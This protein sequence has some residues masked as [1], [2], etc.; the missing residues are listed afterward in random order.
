MFPVLSAAVLAAL[1][2]DPPAAYLSPDGKGLKH[3]LVFREEQGGFA[4]TSV[5][6]WRVEPAGKWTLAKFLV[7]DGKERS[8]TRAAT[9]GTLPAADLAKLATQLAAER[10]LDLPAE[11]GK[12]GKVNPHTYKLTFGPKTVTLAG[13]PPRLGE[14]LKPNLLAA[15]PESDPTAAA[16]RR[17]AGVAE[18]LAKLTAAEVK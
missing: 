1:A 12:P 16:V 9:T 8:D 6:E 11:M 4:G 7:V 18:G 17:L 3:P 5:L 2:G 10:L 15:V 13:A 14:P